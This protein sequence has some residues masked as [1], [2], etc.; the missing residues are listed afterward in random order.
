MRLAY[1]TALLALVA[2]LSPRAWAQAQPHRSANELV[3][4]NGRAV[5]GFDVSQKRITAFLE[6]PYRQ[7]SNGAETRDVAFDVYPG[8]RVGSSGKW[9]GE[10][11]P[12]SAG[13]ET[14]TGI[15]RVTRSH[16][17]LEIDEYIF[18]PIDLPEHA[19][20][21]LVRVKRLS[22]SGGV[23]VYGLF[24]FHLGAGS[25][26]PTS[27]QETISWDAT[28]DAFLEWGPSGLTLAYGSIGASAH[29]AASPQNPYP[30]LNAGQNLADNA[31]TGGAFDDAVGG[32]QWSLGDIA[33]GDTKW[34][35][36]YVVLDDKSNVTPRIDAVKTWIGT[37][38]PDQILAAEKA[39]WAGWHTPVPSGLGL[40]E[41][42]LYRQQMA[43]LRM[44]QVREPGKGDGQILASLPPGMWNIS[45]VR[46]MS[47]AVAALA[48]SGHSAEAKRA[49]EFQLGA[50]SGKYQSYVG[51]PYQISITRYYG[52]G[53]EETDSNE[54]GPNIEFDGFGLFLW[55]VGEYVTASKDDASLKAWWPV[56]SDKIGDVLVK[57]QEPN[58]LIAADSSIWEVHWNG[59]QKHFAYTTLTAAAGLCWA[60]NL[61]DKVGDGARAAS[62]RAAGKKS[63][64]ALISHLSAPDGTLAQSS[65]DLAAGTGFLDAAAI[66]A[67]GLGLIDPKGKAAK[68]TLS[69]MQQK[70]VPPSLRGFMRNDDGGWYDSQEWVFVDLRAV[71][72]M[73]LGAN[74]A[75]KDLLGWITAQGTENFGLISELHEATTA[76]YQGEM[77]MVGF[78]AGAY[79]LAVID[80]ASGALPIP[81]GE[82]AAEGGGGSGTG[83]AAGI[84]CGAGNAGSGGTSGGGA[85]SGGTS[86]GGSGAGGSKSN[87]GDDDGGCGC[88]APG[89]SSASALGALLLALAAAGLRRAR[90]RAP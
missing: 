47:Y 9:L 15:I 14:G 87:G 45:W 82:Y 86:S 24:N 19:F 23:H 68:A 66:E 72:V 63:Q 43:I 8:V 32:L 64:A 13:Y 34:S 42:P 30:A 31:G 20:V 38:T 12:S 3:S 76:D 6:H 41:D 21:N 26:V 16:A 65:E 18:S 90:R 70:L 55:T 60:A 62:Y 59:Q 39:A 36:S 57:L 75:S 25:P 71:N 77:P 83:G 5:V 89:R 69:S 44:G 84:G 48:K 80:R 4:S 22:G 51:H 28:R 27:A 11:A 1:S 50:D 74:P 10:V 29:H 35:G 78:G 49:I 79:S 33:V 52:D 40:T 46:D 53:V 85:S 73:Q 17:G 88:R 7:R 67:V 54:N 61:A 37:K 81:C 56:I 58:G 2:S